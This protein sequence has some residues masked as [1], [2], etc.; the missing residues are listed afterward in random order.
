MMKFLR[1]FFTVDAAIERVA[2]SEAKTQVRCFLILKE[3]QPDKT[4]R[5]LYV[6]LISGRMTYS[7]QDAE[8]LVAS[9][10]EFTERRGIPLTLRWVVFRLV[11]EDFYRSMKQPLTDEQAE[12]M[13]DIISRIIPPEL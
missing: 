11:C 8:A 13:F 3:A 4:N 5:E 6:E 1:R 10:A 7:R 2:K 12:R 9:V